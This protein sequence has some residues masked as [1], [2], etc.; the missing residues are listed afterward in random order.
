[1]KRLLL[2][3]SVVTVLA[4]TSLMTPSEAEAGCRLRFV[5]RSCVRRA[6][7]VCTPCPVAPKT[8][9]KTVALAPGGQQFTVAD[10]KF[11]VL[12][13]DHKE[14]KLYRWDGTANWEF[15]TTLPPQ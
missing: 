14:K 3:I 10:T 4:L 13:I 11:G 8:A 15:L 12:L 6:C 1:M 5:R 9:Q 7:C 2:T